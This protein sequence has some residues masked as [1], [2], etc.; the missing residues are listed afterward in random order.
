VIPL[1]L[2]IGATEPWNAAGL[3]LD[4]RALAACDVR[5]LTIVCGVTAQDRDGLCGAAPIAPDLIAAQLRAIDAAPL[6][7]VRIGALLDRASVESVA[8]WL[9]GRAAGGRRVPIAYDPVLGPSGGGAFADTLALAAIVERLVPL[10]DLIA[11]N[12]AEIAR[13]TEDAV[14]D[15]QD[16]MARA[17]AALRERGAR[18]VL[19][20]GGHLAGSPT[21]VRVSG[22]GTRT[23]VGSRLPGTLRGT[24]CLLTCAL[25][26]ELARGAELD[27]AIARAR[28]FVRDRFANAIDVAGMRVAY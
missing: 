5:A 18:A 15:T 8:G 3:G 22:D 1:V 25:A 11:P 27:D 7:A 6:G 21:D 28:G 2:S 9:E 16:A 26:A 19:V 10:V 23:F 14:P 17:G 4:I 20:T 12:L 13:L 24:G